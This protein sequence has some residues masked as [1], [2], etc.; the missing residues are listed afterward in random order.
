MTLEEFL[1][2][3]HIR[4][5]NLY[6]RFPGFSDLYV[7]KGPYLIRTETFKD[8][9]ESIQIANVSASRPGNGAFRKLIDFLEKNY[10]DRAI[11]VE[12]VLTE[13]LEAVCRHM[14][15]EQI[16]IGTGLHFARNFS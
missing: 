2:P 16:N 6:V 13:Q 5:R 14:K 12:C 3:D 9:C 4:P 11:L 7:R 15:F 8:Y 10:P 1:S